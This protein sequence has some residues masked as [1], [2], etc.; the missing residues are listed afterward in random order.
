[1]QWR[2]GRRACRAAFCV[3]R[4]AVLLAT[5]CAFTLT[6]CE[7]VSQPSFTVAQP[8][9]ASVAFDSIDGL[10]PAQF[11]TLVQDLNDE[12]QSRRLAVISRENPS[13]YRVRGYLSAETAKDKTTVS[14]VWDVF[15]NDQHRALRITGTQDADGQPHEGWQ[16]VDGETLRKIARE[17]MDQL[18]AFLTS[19]AVAPGAPA[20]APA[21]VAFVYGDASTP[22][23]AG[24]FRIF[25]AHADPVPATVA[26]AETD[27]GI[28]ATPISAAVP[29][30]RRRPLAAAAV[31]ARET[32]ML[33]A[34]RHAA[35]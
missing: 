23:A 12:A 21:H 27:T 1:M 3:C 33:A 7:L 22:E 4:P 26:P 18:A 2:W 19:P 10:P 15:D 13:A 30:P 24:I 34:A 32:L 28:A 16:A 35:R 11:Q 20:P 17:S 25:H 8:R 29:L 6:A 14:W 9:G 31:S 5:A